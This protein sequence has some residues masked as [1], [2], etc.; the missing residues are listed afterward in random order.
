M[1]RTEAMVKLLNALRE[2]DIDTF[3]NLYYLLAGDVGLSFDMA[4]CFYDFVDTD[5]LAVRIDELKKAGIREDFLVDSLL[6]RMQCYV[7]ALPER[8]L[9]AVRKNIS[10]IEEN[11][12]GKPDVLLNLAKKTNAR[13]LSAEEAEK[14]LRFRDAFM[15]QK[16]KYFSH[17]Q[18]TEWEKND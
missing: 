9:A 8:A 3:A 17:A 12:S 14:Q 1:T 2:E 18:M 10:D 16:T 11:P 13:L 5:R 4:A 15:S 6:Y 7:E